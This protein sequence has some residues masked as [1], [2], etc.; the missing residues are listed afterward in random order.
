[1]SILKLGG[2]GLIPAHCSRR[3]QIKCA[4]HVISGTL[5]F[6]WMSFLLGD[7]LWLRNCCISNGFLYF[8]FFIC[9]YLSLYIHS[10][11]FYEGMVLSHRPGSL[12]EREIGRGRPKTTSKSCTDVHQKGWWL[13][14]MINLVYIH[15]APNFYFWVAF[16]ATLRHALPSQVRLDFCKVSG[17]I[18]RGEQQPQSVHQADNKTE[19]ALHEANRCAALSFLCDSPERRTCNSLW[20]AWL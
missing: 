4:G 6:L 16:I 15:S 12:V 14:N 3:E 19:E 10:L 13:V 8:M 9:S 1:M 7:C 5:T 17:S 11:A 2:C 18:R 20:R